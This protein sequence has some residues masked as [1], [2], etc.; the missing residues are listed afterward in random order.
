MKLYKFSV[1]LVFVT[2]LALL[3]V[4]QQVRLVKISY[5]IEFNEREITTLL[6]QNKSL[7]YNIA[8]LKSPVDL[9]KKLL[10]SKKEFSIPQQ[11]KVVEVVVPKANKDHIITA[12]TNAQTPLG[13]L[14]RLGRPKEVFANTIK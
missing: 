12:K 8:K 5:G 9:E 2:L 4:H 11:W 3:Y 6:D 1:C 7:M 10:A 13:F 14:K